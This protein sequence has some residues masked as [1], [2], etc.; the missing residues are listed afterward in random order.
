MDLD[1]LTCLLLGIP[2]TNDHKR[3]LG[4]PKGRNDHMAFDTAL[5]RRIAQLYAHPSG[6]T[7]EAKAVR[8]YLQR[9]SNDLKLSTREKVGE[10][11]GPE[12]ELTPLDQSII[13]VLIGEGGWNRQSRSRLVAVAASYQITVGGLMRILQAF[14]EASRSGAGPLSRKSLQ[15][16]RVSREWTQLPTSKKSAM[17][18]VDNFLAQTA[19]KITP[20]LSSP[21]PVMTI[22]IAVLFGLLTLLAFVLSLSVLLSP[23]EESPAVIDEISSDRNSNLLN[24]I[25]SEPSE[26]HLVGFDTYPTFSISTFNSEQIDKADQLMPLIK[27]L[28]DT[29]T[30]MRDELL[31]GN[32]PKSIWVDRWQHLIDVASIGWTQLDQQ[33]TDYLHSSI[34]SFIVASERDP[35]LMKRL[36]KMLKP[37]K[38][39]PGQPF[40]VLQSTWKS[41]VLAMLKCNQQLSASARAEASRNQM[42]NITTCDIDEARQ[43]TLDFISTQA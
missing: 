1:R 4:V 40:T 27:Q 28:Q 30:A 26:I 2:E 5:R 6:R 18:A 25:I 35:V 21:S 20:E 38:A 43:Q 41:G 33:T 17:S 36:M 31:R 10:D 22:K 16:N 39:L 14:A 9:I 7:K 12:I 15:T 19:K 37:D 23:D 34:V 42:S 8:D 29:S 11:I 3:I 24:H 32:T 13:A